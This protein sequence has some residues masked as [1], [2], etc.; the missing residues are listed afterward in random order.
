MV[1][2]G[3]RVGSRSALLPRS[4]WEVDLPDAHS[5]YVKERRKQRLTLSAEDRGRI[6]RLAQDVPA[7]WRAAT[8]TQAD[9]KELLGLLIQQ[10]A[11]VPEDLPCR[12]TRVRILWHTGGT[13]EVAVDR[14]EN[15]DIFRTPADCIEIIRE[16]MATHTDAQLAA[17]LTG[18]HLLTGRR[19]PWTALA[20]CTARHRHD[21]HRYK[22]KE[23]ASECRQMR[24]DGRYPTRAVAA[25]LGVDRS[26][27]L[28]W[29]RTGLL[30]G[31]RDPDSGTWWF[32]LPPELAEKL[33][34]RPRIDRRRRQPAPSSPQVQDEV[35][36]E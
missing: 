28:Y 36:G 26:T 15:H 33:R 9:R 19:K 32:L 13:T 25:L 18:R 3:K 20:V 30:P 5:A 12:Q 31:V 16:L 4:E 2:D 6:L 17:V 35:H 34:N 8:T 14:P 29:C 1:Q 10:V 22:K 21:L 24:A 11:L 23:R 7:V 27:V